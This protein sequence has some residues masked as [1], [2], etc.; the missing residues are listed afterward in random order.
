MFMDQKIQYIVKM[1]VFYDLIY[2]VNPIP[3]KIPVVFLF[4]FAEIDVLI[5]KL[6][7]DFKKDTEWS[8][9]S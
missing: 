8:K 5:I 9:L 3:N 2:R 4:L 7:W 6:I 1:A